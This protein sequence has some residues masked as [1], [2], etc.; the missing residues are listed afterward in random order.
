MGAA[1]AFPPVSGR[2]RQASFEERP[3]MTLSIYDITVPAFLRGFDV[4]DYYMDRA[5]EAAEA[6]GYDPAVLVHARLYPDMIGLAGQIQR[7]SDTAKASIGRL[8]GLDVPSFAD[9]E[10]S[11]AELKGRIA[12][13]ADFIRSVPK[14]AFAASEERTIE[15][16]FR[17]GT[18]TYTGLSYALEF[19]LPNFYFHVTTAHDILRHNGIAIGKKHYLGRFN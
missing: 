2:L 8:T 6:G 19:M 3:A 9:T 10:S 11:L 15:I 17:A 16:K 13:T 5:A 4:L 12:R 14:E 18:V 1:L 7:A